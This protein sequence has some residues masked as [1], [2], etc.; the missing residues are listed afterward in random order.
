[1]PGEALDDA[2]RAAAEQRTRGTS[3]ILT[4][5]GE[6]LSEREQA[7][8]VAAHYRSVLDRIA[9]S[10][11]D[12]HVSIKPTQLG[13]DFDR[14]LCARHVENLVDYSRSRAL[15]VWLDME[16]SPY[17]DATLD[18]F[19][20][21]C[22][23]SPHVGVA[24]QAYLYRT[25]QDLERLMSIAP[26]VRLVKGAYLEP[27][28]LAFPKKTDVD[29]NYFRLATRVL[30]APNGPV[31]HIATHDARLIARIRSVIR[32]QGL[33]RSRYEFAMLYG[34]Q[35]RLQLQLAAEGEPTRVLIAYGDNWFPWY[36]RRL[37]ERP[38]NVWFIIRNM[39]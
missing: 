38:A 24:L 6:N 7:D 2:L 23:R 18:L 13:L 33:A 12:A 27:P 20:R 26:A 37:A 39:W 22:Q 36:M 3:A 34:I 11:L 19:Q 14:E 35:R 21:A 16:S 8:A 30:A 10:G 5:L 31:V 4:H 1:M 9:A 17:V 29:D 15:F 25:A 28:A 32:E